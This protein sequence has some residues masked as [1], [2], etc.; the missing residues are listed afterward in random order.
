MSAI[1]LRSGKKPQQQSTTSNAAK[2]KDAQAI[3]NDS[4]ANLSSTKTIPLPFSTE[5]RKNRVQTQGVNLMNLP[6]TTI[7]MERM[8][9]KMLRIRSTRVYWQANRSPLTTFGLSILDLHLLDRETH[10]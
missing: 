2:G 8:I 7:A 5:Q 9:A 4:V 6:S 1:T 10:L 3:V